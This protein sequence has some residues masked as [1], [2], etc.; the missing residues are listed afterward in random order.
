MQKQNVDTKAAFTNRTTVYRI[1]KRLIDIII[2]LTMLILLSPVYLIISY[3][4]YRKEG[5]TI[6]Y[7]EKRMGMN[8]R[9]FVMWT[10]RT[11]T[12]QSKVIRTL[13]P[14]P[15]PASWAE[16]VPNK[17]KF[18]K[19]GRQ[20]LTET[21]AMLKKY[22]LHKIPQFIHVLKGEMSLVGPEPEIPEITEHYNEFQAK[23]HTVKPGITGYAQI[24]G[25]SNHQH[26]QKIVR[27]IYY[28][29]HYSFKLD[30]K[31]LFK[32]LQGKLTMN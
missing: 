30:M 2:S 29:N 31:I 7:R 27:D 15:V 3:R 16:G 25:C 24:H 11:K 23:R 26:R 12:N 4:I 18:K 17:F 6:F 20:T 9:T 10:F 28:I 32:T 5:K 8:N 22:S 1:L 13:P 14:R 19:Y 21:G